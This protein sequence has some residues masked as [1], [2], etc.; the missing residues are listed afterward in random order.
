MANETVKVKVPNL[1]GFDKSY[2]NILTTKVGTITP[3]VSK[4]VMPGTK[5]TL[6]VAISACL[7]PLASDTFMRANLKVEAF[8]C[9][10]RLLYGGF[11]SWLTGIGF[12]EWSS[13]SRQRAELPFLEFRDTT[14]E[15]AYVGPGTLADY[16]DFRVDSASYSTGITS[17]WN[18]FPFLAYHRIWDDWYRNSRISAALFCPPT[19]MGTG[20]T[21]QQLIYLPYDA[22]ASMRPFDLTSPFA[23]GNG[24]LGDLRQRNYGS[25]YFTAAMPTAQVGT[26][27]A[28]NTTGNSFTISA[29]RAANS[30]QQF[31]ERSG[32]AGRRMQD[33]V[34]AH[35]GADLA[36]GIAQRAILL[37]SASYPVYSKGV[38]ANSA[39]A[40]TNNPFTT[41]GANYGR[42]AASG[43]NFVCRFEC[44]E[45]SYLMVMATLVPEA[46][47]SNGID[48][49]FYML[50]AAGCQVDLPDPILENTGNEPI[51]QGELNG[52]PNSQSPGVFGYVPKNHWFKTSRNTVHGLLRAGQSLDS[53]V[54]QRTFA[55]GS[56][57]T[58]GFLFNRIGTNDL[59][60]VTAVTA[61]LSNYGCW[62][63]SF[64]GLKIVCPLTESAIPSLQDPAY[65]HG[66]T[67]SLNQ[68]HSL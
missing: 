48:H 14:A 51:W 54:A 8:L 26:A 37:G 19:S 29:L 46:N 4:Y 44:N 50:N 12:F 55:S 40:A 68:N 20:P 2:K 47:Y 23:G 43:T 11:E 38:E 64:I 3:I 39:N 24:A 28:V 62:I 34:R 58:V 59:D 66:K 16:L 36:S 57:P 1:S 18:I 45:P 42:G 41:V 49:E 21:V 31:A 56:T 5:G 9:P 63:D 35:Y 17:H 6:N 10:M 15:R 67:V 33:Y 61:D 52:N 13:G 30:V 53:F 22:Y 32:Y 60:N 25:D 7:P 65:E 27:Q